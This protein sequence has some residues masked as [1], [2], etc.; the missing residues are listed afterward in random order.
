[1]IIAIIMIAMSS[2]SQV[3]GKMTDAR[4]GKVYKTVI[5]GTQ[6]WM[7]ENFAYK[8]SSGC[9]PINDKASIVAKYGYYYDWQTAKKVCPSG[10]HLPSDAEWKTLT[11]YLGGEEVA[12]E[13]MKNTKG[14]KKKGNGTNTSGFVALPGGYYS[15][16]ETFEQIGSSGYWW[17][18][19]EKNAKQAKDRS[20][21]Y[22]DGEVSG[23]GSNTWNGLSVRYVKD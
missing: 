13:K 10:W 5:I 19:T 15:G 4:D 12:G 14:W 21:Y 7:A 22:E 17:S 8:A 11:D 16:S 23:F 9:W 3:T 20:M 1:M 6:T 18:S 2:Q